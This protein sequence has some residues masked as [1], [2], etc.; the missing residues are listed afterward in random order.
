MIL[1]QSV[2]F[3]IINYWSVLI[4]FFND[5]LVGIALAH[6]GSHLLVRLKN[7]LDFAPLEK[8]AVAYHHQSGPG[9]PVTHPG[10]KL[11][12]AML[13]KYL[14]DL[15]LREMEER[16]YSDM[17]VRWFVGYTLFDTPPDH[18]T[19]ARFELWLAK[20]QHF[21]LFDEVLRQIRQD[22][23]ND[24]RIQ[25]GDTYAMCAHAARENL[26]PLLQHSSEIILRSA[27][28]AIPVPMENALRGF[29]WIALFGIQPDARED[30]LNQVQRAARLQTVALAALDLHDRLSALLI[31][32]PRHEL[33][34]FRAQ[35]GDLRKILTDEVSLENG[36]VRRLPPKEQGSFRI[37]SATDSEASYRVHGSNPEDTRFGFNVQVAISRNGF[38]CETRAYTGAVPD[39]AGVANL[40]SDQMERL[41]VC[42]EK[43]IYDQAAGCGKTRAEVTRV[44]NGQTQL[45]AKLPSYESR[46]QVFA[47]HDF[48]L[49]ADGKAL[50]CPN[51]CSTQV[52]YRSGAG[53]GRLFRFFDFQ[54]WRGTLP[55]GKKAPDPS[56]A[57]RCPFWE[58]CRCA[59]QGPRSMRQ[60]FISDYRSEVLSAQ[61]YNQSDAFALDMKL[62]PRVERVIFELTHYNGARLC[63]RR[64]LE[65]S[66]WQAKTCATAYNLKLWVRK[67][68]LRGKG[69]L[70]AAAW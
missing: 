10:N 63:R 26:V 3:V 24:Q 31:D 32:R 43:L 33:P 70:P 52:A 12:R 45:S 14:Y 58:R 21:A 18:S 69:A 59:D 16:L 17:I 2:V 40:V 62:R 23:P 34:V 49:S 11:I 53:D 38:V 8:L 55:K 1:Q 64:G 13:V 37:G 44:S 35:L 4:N 19:L 51:Q 54:C 9:A 42:P 47:P 41:G 56:L 27:A 25:T 65:H 30:R 20:H 15:S 48:D 60:V 67:A 39:Q 22:Y 36:V 66:D 28:D 7:M 6:A 5:Y 46:S 61:Q 68:T 57:T 29:D 50:T